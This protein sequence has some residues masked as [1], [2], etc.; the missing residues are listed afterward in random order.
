MIILT[1]LFM[2]IAAAVN[3][4]VAHFAFGILPNK[5]YSR[6]KYIFISFLTIFSTACL[7]PFS[8]G[9]LPYFISVWFIFDYTTL[10]VV[11]CLIGLVSFAFWELEES[12]KFGF[13]KS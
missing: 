12:K 1:I 13:L 8:I 5:S 3:F 7:V 6:K 4:L 2:L 11:F 9:F 10:V